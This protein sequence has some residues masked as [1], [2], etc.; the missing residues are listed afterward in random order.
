MVGMGI[1]VVTM[2]VVMAVIVGMTVV[3]AMAVTVV[4]PVMV[5]TEGDG[6]AIGLTGPR[7]FPFAKITA[8]RQPFH[9]VVMALL[10]QAHLI[11]KTKHLSS[12]LA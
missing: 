8:V 6:D 2:G 9:V 5:R 1:G 7:A 3:V 12:V 11:L 10:G 4:V